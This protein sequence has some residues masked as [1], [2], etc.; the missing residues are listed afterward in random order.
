MEFMLNMDQKMQFGGTTKYVATKFAVGSGSGQKLAMLRKL[1]EVIN[2]DLPP[3][4][5]AP[6]RTPWREFGLFEDYIEIFLFFRS[7]DFVDPCKIV[8]G[9][10]GPEGGRGGSFRILWEAPDRG[11]LDP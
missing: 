6:R 1:P 5:G 11:S 7:A 8:K 3:N 2:S 9:Q 4:H 10:D